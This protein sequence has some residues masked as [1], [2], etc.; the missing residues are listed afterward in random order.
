MR[1]EASEEEIQWVLKEAG[2]YLNPEFPLRRE[3]V[4]SAWSGIRPLAMDPFAAQATSQVSR[5]HLISVNP[6][7]GVVFISGGKWTT[8]REM[9]EVKGSYLD[10][11][12]HLT[13][14]R[15]PSQRS[16]KWLDWTPR[17]LDTVAPLSGI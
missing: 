12:S 11:R 9:A 3:D 10:R 2:K 1:P 8:Y 17:L 4:L 15:M 14:R 6:K 5:D 7:T 13:L 16:S